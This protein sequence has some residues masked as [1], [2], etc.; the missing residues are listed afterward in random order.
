MGIVVTGETSSPLTLLLFKTFYHS[1]RQKITSAYKQQ[2]QN[3]DI[4]GKLSFL[5]TNNL[6]DADNSDKQEKD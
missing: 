1:T 4:T 2:N 3:R 5:T 6:N